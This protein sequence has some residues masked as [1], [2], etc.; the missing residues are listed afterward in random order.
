MVNPDLHRFV[1]RNR[2]RA[3]IRR[4][5]SSTHAAIAVKIS[6]HV[7]G[8]VHAAAMAEL[9]ARARSRKRGQVAV[10][11]FVAPSRREFAVVGDASAH[12]RL[13]QETWDAI[14]A[15]VQEHF[16]AG[17]PTAGLVAGIEEIGRRLAHHFPR[18]P[19]R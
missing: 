11:F 4:A 14:V 7:D 2:V 12:E 1:D 3:A 13:G 5:E 15:L 10:V 18:E 19:T 16:R 17:D 8:D 6:A 9:Q